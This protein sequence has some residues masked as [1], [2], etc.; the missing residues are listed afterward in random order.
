[1]ITNQQVNGL[2]IINFL[3]C[4]DNLE[5]GFVTGDGIGEHCKC[6][7]SHTGSSSLS[8]PTNGDMA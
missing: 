2:Q 5:F 3:D 4:T 1:M 8:G 7:V 6:F